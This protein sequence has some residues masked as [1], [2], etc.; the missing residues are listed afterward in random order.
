VKQSLLV[1]VIVIA[2]AS[3]SKT[4]QEDKDNELPVVT[5][6]SPGN[7]QVFNAGETVSITGNLSDNKKLVEM[8]VHISNITTGALLIDIHRD[9]NAATYAVNE[10]FQTQAGILYKIQV[11]AK[12]NSS[13]ENRASVEISSN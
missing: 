13:N 12:D 1:L 10:S 5:I 7:N 8:H 9:P 2:L 4:S 3:C 6:T 11:I